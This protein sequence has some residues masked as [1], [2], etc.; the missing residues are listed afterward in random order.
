VTPQGSFQLSEADVA[1]ALQ[2]S[3]EFGLN[4]VY[5]VQLL[6]AAFEE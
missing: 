3:A 2:L 4:E 1:M 5:C 6:H